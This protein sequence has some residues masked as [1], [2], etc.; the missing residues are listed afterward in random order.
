[1]RVVLVV[2]RGPDD[3]AVGLD[4]QAAQARDVLDVQQQAAG[5]GDDPATGELAIDHLVVAPGVEAARSAT[6]QGAERPRPRRPRDR[7]R[8]G[9]GGVSGWRW[10][11]LGSEAGGGSGSGGVDGWRAE[12]RGSGLLR[13]L[14][15]LFGVGGVGGCGGGS[16]RGGGGSPS[17]PGTGGRT[18]SPS[19]S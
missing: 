2:A 16:I 5:E 9:M 6:R 15:L 11:G 13:L 14:S 3:G 1:H 19:E 18:G 12:R 4:V 10:W 8:R 17:S 7:G